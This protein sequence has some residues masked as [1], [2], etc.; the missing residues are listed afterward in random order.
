MRKNCIIL[1]SWALIA[2]EIP[3]TEWTTYFYYQKDSIANFM[4]DY[5]YLRPVAYYECLSFSMEVQAFRIMEKLVEYNPVFD[6]EKLEQNEG[7]NLLIYLKADALSENEHQE[8]IAS[9]LIHGFDN[10]TIV[11]AGGNKITYSKK[12]INMPFFLPVFFQNQSATNEIFIQNA[13]EMIRCAYEKDIHFLGKEYTVK[14][15]IYA[16][17]FDKKM[18]VFQSI[19]CVLFIAS[20]FLNVWFLWKRKIH[21]K[22]TLN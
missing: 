10:V 22:N 1:F 15:F 17:E 3:A 11:Y 19:L 7:G 14:P 16:G 5:A 4:E 12:D 20:L 2:S 6:F 13:Y 9:M 21:Q 18:K 8:L